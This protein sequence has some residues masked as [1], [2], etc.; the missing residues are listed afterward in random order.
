MSDLFQKVKEYTLMHHDHPVMEV[1]V[2][3]T[4]KMSAVKIPV[5][6]D[7]E[8]VPLPCQPLSGAL[9]ET[10]LLK[11]ALHRTI[12]DNRAGLTRL[13]L[14][15]GSM[16]KLDLSLM[17]YG[18]SLTDGYWFKPRDRYLSWKD[19]S[20][21][22]C[23]YS[24]DVGNY[25]IHETDTIENWRSPDLTTNG[26]L[27]KIWRKNPDTNKLCLLKGGAAPL[28]ME[29]YN[30]FAA[31]NLIKAMDIHIPYVKYSLV[32]INGKTY[33][34][35][36]SFLGENEEYITASEIIHSGIKPK[37]MDNKQ[38]LKQRCKELDIKGY[39]YFL[40]KMGLIDYMLVNTDRH[41]GNY[42][43]IR[44]IETLEY[45]GPAP[46]FDC[47]TSLWSTGVTVPVLSSKAINKEIRQFKDVLDKM[48]SKRFR[49]KELKEVMEECLSQAIR[50][51]LIDRER[52]KAISRT[53]YE[54][55]TMLN[56]MR[57][58][59]KESYQI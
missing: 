55:A 24:Y 52:V 46:I 13:Y 25:I 59:I 12:P 32:K 5:I 31:S 37:D 41:L 1:D 43:F 40:G 34:M 56:D 53:V 58:K 4:G 50:D 28:H 38:Y 7:K 51:G 26:R 42:G 21:E 44:D 54:K 48:P 35:C 39:E 19:V 15:C 8:R 33:S 47:G 30:E 2:V 22:N 18:V 11:W 6:M 17:S 9:Q 3:T 29:P 23:S 45:K 27:P 49:K 10:A 20:F 57:V 14:E 36:D 16:N